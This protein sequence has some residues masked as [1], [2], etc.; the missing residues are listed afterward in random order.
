MTT[1]FPQVTIPHTEIRL[2]PSAIVADEFKLT[3]ALPPNYGES[4]IDYPVLYLLDANIFFG[5]VTETVRLLQ[6]GKEIPDLLNV[7][8]G[9][10]D[11]RQHLGLRSRDLTPTP[12]DEY[13]QEWLK[14]KSNEKGFRIKPKGSGGAKKFLRFIQREL[15]PFVQKHYRINPQYSVL[16]GDSYGGLFGLYTLFHQPETFRGYIIGSP[17]IWWDDRIIMEYETRYAA[18]HADLHARVFLSVGELEVF[19]PEPAAMVTNMQM[20]AK[21]LHSRNYNGLELSTHIFDNETH[22]SVIPGTMSR[23]LRT[24]FK[25]LDSEIFIAN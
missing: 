16:A 4:S 7:G 6:N 11:D 23:G 25:S 5:M 17:S 3:I 19:E 18:K 9:Y 1:S 24:V 12:D 15:M 14:N 2:L 21:Q 20:L 22:L 10:P 13:T 8:I